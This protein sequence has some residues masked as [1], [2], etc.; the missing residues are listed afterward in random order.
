MRRESMGG[1]LLSKM[2]SSGNKL[3]QIMMRRM[4]SIITYNEDEEEKRE[5]EKIQK[6]N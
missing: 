4:N 1:N 2:V 3:Q 6:K 5:L